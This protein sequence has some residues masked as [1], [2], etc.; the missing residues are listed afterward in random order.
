MTAPA[1]ARQSPCLAQMAWH[2]LRLP[3][4]RPGPDPGAVPA[5]LCGLMAGSRPGRIWG[6]VARQAGFSAVQAL[7]MQLRDQV[8]GALNLFRA[9]AGAFAPGEVRV[10]VYPSVKQAVGG[11]KLARPLPAPAV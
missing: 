2:F 7:P 8:I 3:G 11:A 9:D 1:A 4:T 10:G 5:L 6:L